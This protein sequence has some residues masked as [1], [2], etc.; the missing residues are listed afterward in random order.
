MEKWNE[1]WEM[2]DAAVIDGMSRMREK[3]VIAAK[4]KKAAPRERTGTDTRSRWSATG[5]R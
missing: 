4:Y 2:T 5:V 1:S 3:T